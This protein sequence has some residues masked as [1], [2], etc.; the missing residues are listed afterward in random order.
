MGATFKKL[1]LLFL[2]VELDDE[3][4]LMNG[5]T[6]HYGA[7]SNDTDA[8]CFFE[9]DPVGLNVGVRISN[10]KKVFSTEKGR[11]FVK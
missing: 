2:Q 10:L 11:F 7:M 1:L 5:S 9:R 4:P 6:K 3:S 8:D